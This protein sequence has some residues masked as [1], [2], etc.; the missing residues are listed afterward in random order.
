MCQVTVKIPKAVLY[1]THMTIVQANEWAKKLIALEYYTRHH[2]SL[3]YSADIAE[4]TEEDFI[5]FLGQNGISIFHFDDETEFLE[6]M[7]N[8]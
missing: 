6:E 1:D 3:G 5:Q 7:N 4:M 8:A 2:I